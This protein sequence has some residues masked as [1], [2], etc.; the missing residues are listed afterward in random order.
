MSDEP[1]RLGRVLPEL[2]EP[3]VSKAHPHEHVD[4][5]L[6][7]TATGRKIGKLKDGLKLE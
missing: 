4:L 3:H 5:F 7:D 6:R 1:K 2:S